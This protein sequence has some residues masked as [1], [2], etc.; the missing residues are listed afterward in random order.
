L[1]LVVLLAAAGAG[2]V[3]RD[4]VIVYWHMAV[5]AVNKQLR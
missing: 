2:Y 4:R 5:T 3:F 1:L